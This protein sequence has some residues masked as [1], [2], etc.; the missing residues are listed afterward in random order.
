MGDLGD[1]AESPLPSASAASDDPA[2]TATQGSHVGDRY[3]VPAFEPHSSFTALKERI[4]HH[5]E[6]ASDYYYSLW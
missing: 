4:R 3:E 2:Q 1:V 5:Y 6:L